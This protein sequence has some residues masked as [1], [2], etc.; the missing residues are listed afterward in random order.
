MHPNPSS[1]FDHGETFLARFKQDPYSDH[2]HHN[3][4]YPFASLDDWEMANFLLKSKLSMKLIDE[5]LSLRMVRQMSLSFRT[6]KDLRARAELLPSGPRWKFEVVPTAHPT[7]Q[8]VHLYYRDALECIESLFNHPFFAD[9]IDFTPF[10]LFTTAERVVRVYTEWMSSNSA[11]EMQS[12]IPAGGTLCGVIISSDKTNITR[13]AGGGVAHPLLISLANIKMSVRNKGSS[14]AF[15]LLALLPIARFTHPKKRMC[16]VLDARLFH[17][18]LDI[19]LDPLKK[20]AAIGRMM[21]DPRGNLRYCFT[22]LLASIDCDP[23]LVEEYFTAC[24]LF[25]LSGVSHPYWRDWPFAEPSRFF[26]P[27]GLH[28]WHGEFWSHDVQWCIRGLG[29]AEIDFR[30]SI[31]PPITGLRRFPTGITTLKQVCGRTKRDVQRFLVVVIAGT[32]SPDVVIATRALM[33]FRYMSQAPSL[34][35]ASCDQIKAALQEF[36]HHKNAIIESGLRRGPTTGAILEH[37]RIPKLELLQSVAPSIEQVGSPL[38]WSADTT[39]HAHIEVVKDPASMTNNQN[40]SSQICRSLDRD[41]KCRIFNTAIALSTI[42]SQR[43]DSGEAGK[44]EDDGD[45]YD[46]VGDVLSDLWTSQRKQ[47]N[48]FAVAAQRLASVTSYPRPLR[49]FSHG[50]TAFRLNYDPSLRRVPIDDVAI[51]FNLPDLRPA[52]A[53]YV[54]REGEFAQNF[55][56]FGPRRSGEGAYLPFT[57]LQVWYKVR[58]QQKCYHDP[59]VVAPAFT[60]HACPPNRSSKHSGQY[61]FAT[62]N[63]DEGCVWPSSGLQ[64]HTVV[65]VRLI[66]CPASPK[67]LIGPF[68]N[69]FLMYAQRFD[70]VPQGN[71]EVERTTGLHVLKR[72]T[73]RISG[74]TSTLG[75]VFPLDQLRSFAHVVPRFGRI[76]DNRLTSSNCVEYSESFYLNKYFDKDFFYAIS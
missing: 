5:F 30:F 52:L 75:D 43:N 17:Q 68:S 40:Y 72:A 47:T 74:V 64:G 58:L 45:E 16:S 28:H 2:R 3:L 63:A 49:T 36:H 39:E 51:I 54:K 8:P 9:K 32:M 22:P 33:E 48:F 31:I 50:S 12:Q 1:V 71:N 59:S 7:K 55:H 18:C 26:T 37:W 6:A 13:I 61:D 14:H 19:I 69:R 38:Q 41:E 11:W 4:Y 25:R 24:A 76:A 15:L 62:M 67:G 57:E 35:S 23:L 44:E 20:A 21:S 73:R 42:S 56:K 65:N 10:R 34:T 29:D 53:D 66:M 70:I 60:V 46:E 27:E